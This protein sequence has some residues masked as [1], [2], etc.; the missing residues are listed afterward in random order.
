MWWERSTYPTCEQVT[1]NGDPF[2]TFE[3]IFD[4]NADRAWSCYMLVDDTLTTHGVKRGKPII[5]A[6]TNGYGL[7]PEQAR[8]LGAALVQAADTAQT[9]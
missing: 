2:R 8:E 4:G 3:R 6:A 1:G 7:T 9:I 5:R